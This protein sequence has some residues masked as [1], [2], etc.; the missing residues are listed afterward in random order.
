MAE[1][2]GQTVIIK[3]IKKSGGGHHG[4]AWKLAYAD[5][6]TAMMA[7]FLILWLLN[8]VTQEQ[9]EGISNYFAP[10]STSATTS[11]SGD[12]LAGATMS[13]SPTA[14]L[15]ESTSPSVTVDLPPPKAG[16]GTSDSEDQDEDSTS[17]STSE[18]EAEEMMKKMEEEQFQEAEQ[19]IRETIEGL[20]EFQQ[21]VESLVI[22][23]TPEGLRVQIVDQDGLAMFPSGSTK[24]LGHTRKVM[25]LVTNVV[26]EMPQNISITGHTDSRKFSGGEQGYTNWELSAD[27]ANA[28]RRALIELGIDPKRLARVVGMVAQE[29][30]VADDPVNARN[31][32]IPI[33]LLRGT[34][35]QQA[36]PPAEG[37]EGG[38]GA[39]EAAE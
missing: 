27:R 9:L 34:G 39:K 31:R 5:F 8:S 38:E 22:D 25:K 21:L 3:K 15:A 13:A 14:M 30:F 28:S 17:A 19:K 1:T 33:V 11:G 36:P 12:V 10:A 23:S 26:K 32:R 20:P 37:G 4:G 6:V 24:M 16:T 29:P 2:P 18:E 35:D 7:F